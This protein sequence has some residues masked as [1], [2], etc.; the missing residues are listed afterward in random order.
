M[1]YEQ[2][3]QQVGSVASTAIQESLDPDGVYSHLDVPTYPS[4][5]REFWMRGL[6]PHDAAAEV[7]DVLAGLVERAR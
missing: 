1:T 7:V 2:F 6:T 3:E 5:V 4:I